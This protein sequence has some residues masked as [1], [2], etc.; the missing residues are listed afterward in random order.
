[1]SLCILPPATTARPEQLGLPALPAAPSPAMASLGR[2]LFFDKRLSADGKI[3]CASCHQPERAFIDGKALAQGIGGRLGTRNTPTLLNAAFNTSQFWDGRR[4]TLEEQ[5]LD[6]FVQPREHGLSNHGALLDRLR[7][8][9]AYVKAFRAAF[10]GNA[11]SNAETNAASKAGAIRIQHVGQALASFERTLSAAGS[12]FDRFRYQGE[13]SAL[14]PAAKRGL[15]LFQGRAQCASC[16]VIGPEHAIFTDNQFHG[17]SV[18]LSR[19]AQRLPALT[20]GL[21]QM[22]KQGKALDQAVLSDEDVAE[23]GRFAVTLQPADIGKFRT[24]SLRNVALT[25]PYMHDGSIATLE[26]AVELEIYYR[27][28]ESGH[29]L[30]LTPLEKADLLEF[31]RAL[32]SPA[33][34]RFSA[35]PP[36]RA[37]VPSR[38]PA[39]GRKQD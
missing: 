8:D 2:T 36:S 10:P 24:P 32:D 5:A 30:I 19:I 34:R 39:R 25:A 12:P 13:E 7:R 35:P 16:H 31:L 23:L 29:P 38:A 22:R 1:M 15:L 18:G 27:S 9:S 3:S 11:E 17:L 4:V 37:P 6:P 14:A 20:T 26:E 28:A 33:A 21:V